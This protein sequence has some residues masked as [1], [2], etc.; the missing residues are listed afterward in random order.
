MIVRAL[1]PSGA[2]TFGRGKAN[3]LTGNRAIIQNIKTRLA[4]FL[5]DCFFATNEGIDWF[6]LLGSKD[7]LALQLAV[8]AT[9]LNTEGVTGLVALT[10]DLNPDTRNFS[11]SWEVTTIFSGV[12]DISDTTAATTNYLLTESGEIITTEDGNLIS[13]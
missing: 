3:Y 8:S 13:I 1:T 5:G 12:A 9:I 10:V 2:W 6:N 4:S 7:Q 11:L